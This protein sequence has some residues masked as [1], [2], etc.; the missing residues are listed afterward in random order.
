MT[1]QNTTKHKII[2][3]QCQS[4]SSEFMVNTQEIEQSTSSIISCPHCHS[5]IK[6][7]FCPECGISYS[8]VLGGIAPGRYTAKCKKCATEFYIEI[9]RVETNT[10]EKTATPKPV[11]PAKPKITD[12]LSQKKP[13]VSEKRKQPETDLHQHVNH[14]KE[15]TRQP[16]QKRTAPAALPNDKKKRSP[17]T[18]SFYTRTAQRQFSLK[19][20]VSGVFRSF[21]LNNLLLMGLCIIA[22]GTIAY[23]ASFLKTLILPTQNFNAYAKSFF[24][25][26][27]ISLIFSVFTAFATVISKSVIAANM[28]APKEPESSLSLFGRTLF[29]SVAVGLPGLVL[30]TALLVFLTRIPAAG[31]LL[32]SLV[33]LPVYLG[34]LVGVILLTVGIWFLPSLA[35]HKNNSLLGSPAAL[36]GFI[37]KYNFR[38][39]YI[40]PVLFM[41]AG[42]II[43]TLLFLHISA[44]TLFK[45]ISFTISGESAGQALAG[46]PVLFSQIAGYSIFGENA[47][48]LNFLNGGETVL[49]QTGGFV[50]GM[51]FTAITFFIYVFGL[52]F[53][54]IASS[55]IY[56]QL[57]KEKDYGD[58]GKWQLFVSLAFMYILLILLK[59]L[60][61]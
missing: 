29:S 41:I 23:S 27:P 40:I 60:F 36:V 3:T 15:D 58:R 26:I 19:N 6:L 39:F 53:A 57:E 35:V 2:S 17:L 16:H 43:G 21:S 8:I 48:L 47:N 28:M 56:V 54:V 51:I 22:A 4:C 30:V 50:I 38:L 12:P 9:P 20:I 24:Q 55:H 14:Q 42:G 13:L 49:A 11:F 1:T 37:R 59:I 18:E 46:I 10:T 45:V 52:T 25:I 32:F 61:T 34:S 31:T 5:S 7:T 33:F 44:L